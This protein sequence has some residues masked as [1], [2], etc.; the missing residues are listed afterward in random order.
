MPSS[1]SAEQAQR[2]GRAAHL[3]AHAAPKDAVDEGGLGQ[4]GRGLGR[5]ACDA[6]LVHRVQQGNEELVSVLL[7]AQA[8]AAQGEGAPGAVRVKG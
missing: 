5:H 6:R 1:F 4:L 3:A 8:E 2:Q 7:A